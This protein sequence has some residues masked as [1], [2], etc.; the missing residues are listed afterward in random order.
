MGLYLN[1]PVPLGPAPI[2]H[3]AF[4]N[5]QPAVEKMFRARDHDYGQFLWGSPV[6]DRFQGNHV[7]LIAMDN[8]DSGSI[9]NIV[10][11]AGR[12]DWRSAHSL[13]CRCHH[14]YS[15]R[16]EPLRG[17]RLNCSTERKSRQ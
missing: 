6:Q 17:K 9:F 7:I 1:N 14:D 15:L 11:S 13:D 8:Q 10:L 16:L 3:D 2:D 12:E 5:M 4:E